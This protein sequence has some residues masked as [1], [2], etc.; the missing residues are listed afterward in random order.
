M[1]VLISG[2]T[3]LIGSALVTLL[4]DAGHDVVRL[5]RS[6]P[7]ADGLAVHWDPE[8][9]RID[10]DR[11]EGLDAVVHLAGENIGAGRWSRDRKA[12]I[13]DSR[14]KGTRLLCE[15]LANL[16]HPPQVLVCASAIGYYGSRG[17]EVMNEGSESG[18]GFLADVC[19]EWE[20]ATE[21]V[22][23]T[24]IRVVNLR[25]GIV[26]SLAGG[27]LEK[28]LPPFKMG[29]GGILG[30]GRQYMSW[31]TLDDAV[32]AIQHTLVTD[33][34]QGPVNNVAPYPVTNRE[35]TKA[36]GRV[37]RRPTLFPLPSFGLRIMFGREMANELFLSSTRVEP[38]RLLETG[39]AFQYPG[40]E[41]ALRHVLG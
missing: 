21:F 13:F 41:D 18:A 4:T 24:E 9:G 40:L 38:T 17:A 35:F 12:R 22:G 27:P 28:M 36:L 33:S 31:I 26:L 34:L 14:V 1:K 11:L 10:T 25:M 19:R 3:G 7:R 39:Y 6:A 5:V 23:Q 15:S 16:N 29:V 37:L 32:G 8:S 20:I 30:N 2:S